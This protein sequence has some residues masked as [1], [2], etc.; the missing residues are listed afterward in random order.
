MKYGMQ[1]KLAKKIGVS[2]QYMSD[3][4]TRRRRVSYKRAKALEG[5]SKDIG[6]EVSWQDWIENATSDNPIFKGRKE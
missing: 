1:I 3:I 5:A 2:T 4:I 6:I